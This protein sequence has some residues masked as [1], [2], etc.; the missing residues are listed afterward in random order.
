M[1]GL[2]K[3]IAGILAVASAAA[4]VIDIIEWDL[5]QALFNLV[6]LCPCVLVAL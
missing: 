1:N 5:S 2:I 3:L 4:L 6:A